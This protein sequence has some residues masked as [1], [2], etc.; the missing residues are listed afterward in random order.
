MGRSRKQAT[1]CSKESKEVLGIAAN[2]ENQ[3][4]I[5]PKLDETKYNIWESRM[6]GYLKADGYDVWHYV[7]SGNT[8]IDEFRRYNTKSM[9]VILR[10]LSD[11]PKSKVD[12]F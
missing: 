10:D 7:V 11:Y 12:Q 3:V 4:D 8:S 1:K 6:E 2:E 9:N 5:T